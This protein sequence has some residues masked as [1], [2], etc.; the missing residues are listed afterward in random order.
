MSRNA[1][2]NGGLHFL[3]AKD[4]GRATCSSSTRGMG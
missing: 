2:I 1:L 4:L 3:A